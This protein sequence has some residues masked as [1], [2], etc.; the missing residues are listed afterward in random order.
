MK[1]S[2]SI[3]ALAALV[4]ALTAGAGAQQ[5]TFYTAHAG[6]TGPPTPTAQPI[7]PDVYYNANCAPSKGS[8]KKP[9][10]GKNPCTSGHR[11]T[12]R[13]S[14]KPPKPSPRPTR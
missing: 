4:A 2:A 5:Q 6:A 10:G 14:G 7:N 1:R 11:P 8:G 13:P 9:H 3:L 12:P